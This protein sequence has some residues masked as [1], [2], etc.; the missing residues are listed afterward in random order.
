MAHDGAEWLPRVIE[1]LHEQTRPVHRIVAVDAG[2]RDRSGTVLADLLGP[3]A[4]FGMDRDAGYATSVASALRHP[5]AVAPVPGPQGFAAEWIWLLHDD[6]APAP[7]A[8]AELLRGAAETPAAAVL[9]PKVLDWADQRVIL[10]AG[11]AIDTAGRRVSGVEPREIDQGQHDGDRDVLAVSSAGML[12]RRDVWDEVGGFDTGLALFREDVDFCWRVHAAGYRVRLVTDAVLHHVEASGR[13]RRDISAVPRPRRADRRNALFV[14]LANL[15]LAAMLTAAVGNAA[16][17]TARILFFL[18]A[19]RPEAAR[20]EAAALGSLAARPGRLLRARKRRRMRGRRRAYGALRSQVPRGQS[21]RKLL[22]FAAATLYPSSRVE[23]TGSHH[24]SDDPS[25]DESLLIDSGFATRFLTN[26]GVLLFT[27]LLVLSLIAERSLLG[28][29]PLG[30]GA[31]LP[32]WGGASGLWNE[33]L[34]GFH[35][36]G[37]GSAASTP[38]Y[39]AVLATVSTILLG[40]P[41]LAVE[42]ILLGC[43]PLAGVTAY[44]TSRRFSERVGVRVWLAASYALLP[45][46][47]GVVAAGRVGAAVVFILVPLIVSAAG[48]MLTEPERRA[49]RFAWATG[50]LITLAAAFVPLVWAMAVIIA[51]FAGIAFARTRRTMAINLGIVALVPPVLLAPWTLS[52]AEHPSGLL[53]EAGLQSPGL[54][55][56]N[57][58]AKSLLLLNPGGPGTP[59]FWVAGGL[60]LAALAALLMRRRWFDVAAAWGVAL[61]GLLAAIAV[62][63]FLVSSPAGG[64]AVPAWPGVAL[65]VAAL[66][67]LLAVAAV[68]GDLY[69]LAAGGGLRRIGAGVMIVVACLPP[70]LAAGYWVVRGVSGPVTPVSGPVLPE[71]VSVSSATGAQLRTLVLRP[72]D[73]MVDYSVLRGTDPPLGSTDLTEPPSATR[74][75]ARVV[76]A[77]AAPD[78]SQTGDLGAALARFGIGYVLLPAPVSPA[79]A[80]QIDG[81]L[82]LRPVSE[83]PTFQL[84]RVSGTVAR[85]TVTEPS[86]TQVALPSGSLN[87]SGAAAPSAGGTVVLAEPASASW[88]ATLNGRPLAPLAAPVDGWAQG[89]RLPAGGG[90]LSISRDETGRAIAVALEFLAVFIVAALALPGAKQSAAEEAAA[91]GRRRTARP[92]RAAPPGQA[93]GDAVPG[94]G[95]RLTGAGRARRGADADQPDDAGQASAAG[96]VGTLTRGG[97]GRRGTRGRE[98]QQAAPRRSGR[99]ARAQGRRRRTGPDATGTGPHRVPDAARGTGPSGRQ[100]GD[101]A[102]AGGGLRNGAPA[103]WDHDAPQGEWDRDAPHGEWDRDAPHGEWEQAAPQGEGDRDAPQGGW[104]YGGPPSGRQQDVPQGGW[105]RGT[106]QGGWNHDGQQAGRQ[107]D[108]PPG[109]WN[110]DAHPGGWSQDGPSAGWDQD[111]P[112]GGWGADNGQDEW[113][114]G[115]GPG[116][117]QPGPG[118]TPGGPV[119]RARET[120]R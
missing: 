42:V 32:A 101:E 72:Q 6:S 53:V 33:Y 111:N 69:A 40:K 71:Y 49:R 82:G 63:R 70:V 21:L 95:N 11:L 90:A 94:R 43:V 80:G 112:A 109:G 62:S 106:P 12:A 88:H 55:S 30:G 91:A 59:P 104:N 93:D 114:P 45:V 97:T 57:L 29:G 47:T 54:A 75:L 78:G 99:G 22:E 26:P 66:G 2:S 51:A 15:P 116:A 120:E 56:Q 118:W 107:Q 48:R 39:I 98:Q 68:G 17:S 25:D 52:L 105:D 41:W 35:A 38:P 24:A 84:W 34:S 81:V 67:L 76:A 13:G 7:D 37:I 23:A 73:G 50:L 115:P 87:V 89:F 20:D 18:L 14:L 100:A 85:V 77:L 92:S 61:S 27:G 31:L 74:P 9:G 36:V 19:K 103:G 65:I 10:E 58:P 64:P 113:P 108:T 110:Q 102:R 60:V 3:D 119:S 96:R 4:V 83:T 44:L 28:P 1:A 117:D 86:G 8:L 16:L 79:L 46:A 5:A